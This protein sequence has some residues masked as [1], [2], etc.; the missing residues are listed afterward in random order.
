MNPKGSEDH[1]PQ[2]GSNIIVK[3]QMVHCLPTPLA[4]TTPTN[5]RIAPLNKVIMSE[6]FPP[7]CCPT[8]K[9]G[10]SWSLDTLDTFPRERN[11]IRASKLCLV[12]MHI[13]LTRTRQ[14]LDY[15]ITTISSRDYII[16]K[17]QKQGHRLHFLI[18][19]VP[20]ETAHSNYYPSLPFGKSYWVNKGIPVNLLSIFFYW[21][22]VSRAFLLQLISGVHRPSV[23]SFPQVHLGEFKKQLN[24]P[25]LMASRFL[26]YIYI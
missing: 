18:M 7:S 21:H 6:N 11:I 23:R 8:K 25:S 19:E 10:L 17:L 15:H 22:R 5:K 4:H 12:G 1:I 13:K 3:Q 16:K 2:L 20:Y 26:F 9:W 24:S 14:A